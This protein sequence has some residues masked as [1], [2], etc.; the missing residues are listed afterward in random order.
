MELSP[1]RSATFVAVLLRALDDEGKGRGLVTM[2][3]GG[4][5]RTATLIERI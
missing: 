2:C 4:D 1:D 5:P 3:C